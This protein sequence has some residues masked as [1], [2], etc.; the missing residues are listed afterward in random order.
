MELSRNKYQKLSLYNS[1]SLLQKF[2]EVFLQHHWFSYKS[3]PTFGNRRYILYQIFWT[4]EWIPQ[5][6]IL[7][8]LDVISSFTNI[9]KS[10]VIKIIKKDWR[11]ISCYT[12]L[13]LEA[14]LS[15]I[16]FYVDSDYFF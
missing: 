12:N 4:G 8:S 13:T 11:F 2:Y 3:E 10:L 14:L 15:P 1:S 7:I 6:Y 5:H 16:E 9:L